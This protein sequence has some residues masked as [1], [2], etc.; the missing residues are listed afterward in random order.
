M[1]YKTETGHGLAPCGRPKTPIAGF[2][3]LDPVKNEGMCDEDVQNLEARC[4]NAGQLGITED[5]L[6][7]IHQ[8][9]AMLE[10]FG[11]NAD[12]LC[13][14]H[15]LL[16]EKLNKAHDESVDGVTPDDNTMSIIQARLNSSSAYNALVSGIREPGRFRTSRTVSTLV[17]ISGHLVHVTMFTW[18]GAEVCPIETYFDNGYLGYSDG[19][20][21][22]VVV[23]T[24]ADIE[25]VL[26]Y[27]DLLLRQGRNFHFFRGLHSPF[28]L[29]LDL[30]IRMF[31]LCGNYSV[32]R[33]EYRWKDLWWPYTGGRGGRS[34]SY[35]TSVRKGTRLPDIYAT[36]E[37]E[38]EG[39]K[40]TFTLY[41]AM[42]GERDVLF[43]Y[44][45]SSCPTH[46]IVETIN[47]HGMEIKK[48]GHVASLMSVMV[49]ARVRVLM[50]SVA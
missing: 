15:E 47:V 13:M 2:T 6:M 22:F 5:L 40:L 35:K 17:Q 38:V 9:E 28:R 20:R 39:V 25:E 46:P 50:N 36:Y 45:K 7:R 49:A 24:E 29:N 31:R 3:E 8:D 16:Q 14:V 42:I 33:P 48:E 30:Y 21:D 10:S 34:A 27:G 19:F 43:M 41:Y 26:V 23:S 44:V 32:E 12:D 37:Q 4:R 11:C 1:H 18:N